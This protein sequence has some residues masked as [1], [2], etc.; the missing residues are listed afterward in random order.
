MRSTAGALLLALCSTPVCAAQQPAAPADTLLLVV[1][2]WCAPCHG[3]LRA[4]DAIAA[5]ARP[6]RTLVVAYDDTRATRAMLR[7]IAPD[8]R[9]PVNTPAQRQIRRQLVRD[10]VGLP[11]AVLTD[12]RGDPCATSNQGLNADRVR[13]LRQGCAAAKL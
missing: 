6:A 4:L 8:H 10:A 5:A 9:W 12:A 1:A 11:Y 13:R 7:A 2:S 3:E